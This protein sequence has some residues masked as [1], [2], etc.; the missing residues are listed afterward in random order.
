MCVCVVVVVVVVVVVGGGGD[1]SMDMDG[2]M[3]VIYDACMYEAV[4]PI[5][6]SKASECVRPAIKMVWMINALCV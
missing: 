6:N 2:S 1:E 3:D 4:C 5:I